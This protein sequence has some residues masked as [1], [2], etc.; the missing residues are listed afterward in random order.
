MKKETVLEMVN[1]LPPK[2]EL[3]ELIEKLILIEAIE[4]AD[5][6]VDNDEF[7]T[8]DQMEVRVKKW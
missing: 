2:F 6:Q 7:Y 3:E 5:K 1:Q 4:A 8:Q